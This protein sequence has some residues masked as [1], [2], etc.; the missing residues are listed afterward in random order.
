ME[1]FDEPGPLQL[2]S[3]LLLAAPALQDPN[4]H[5]TAILVTEHEPTQGAQGYVLNR[6][7]GKTVGQ[8][9]TGPE[10]VPLAEVP[11]CVGGPVSHEKLTFASFWWNREE[12]SLVPESHLS[13]DQAVEALLD[14]K[15]VRAFVGYSGWREGQLEEE[16]RQETWILHKGSPWLA[17]Q[18]ATEPLWEKLL[19]SLGPWYQLLAATPGNPTLN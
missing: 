6:P 8:L 18:G 3:K 12:G 15:T 14:G 11:V 1:S 9:L 10:F 17:E 13:H 19:E 2:R 16:L 5:R 4:F 7:L